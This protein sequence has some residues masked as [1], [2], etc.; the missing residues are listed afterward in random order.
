MSYDNNLRG[1]LFKND[2]EGNISRP[3]YR[4]ECDIEGVPYRISAWLNKAR[5]G[6]KYMS[7]K[8]EPK[9]GRTPKPA[10]VPG[11]KPFAPVGAGQPFDDDIPF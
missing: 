9:G 8:F 11:P 2:K 10:D 6:S 4:G 3:D 1:A 7:L 5:D